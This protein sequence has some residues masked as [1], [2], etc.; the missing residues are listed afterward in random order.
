VRRRH[1]DWSSTVQRLLAHVRNDGITWVPEPL[2]FDDSEREVLSYVEGDPG[3]PEGDA[4]WSEGL[5]AAVARRLREW[6]D[7]TATFVQTDEDAWFNPGRLPHEVIA[8]NTFADRSHIFTGDQLVGVIH[9]DHCY[10]ASRLWDI[11]YTAYFYCPLAPP[12]DNVDF[13][14]EISSPFDIATMQQRLEAFLS[15]YGAVE[16]TDGTTRTYRPDEVTTMLATRLHD[17]ADRA[18]MHVDPN[19]RAQVSTYRAHAFWVE[20]GALDAW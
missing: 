9:F 8:H 13:A 17:M 11:A 1:S 3:V 6:H 5:L 19:L 16:L 2:G 18:D 7:S 12:Q 14:G 10:P 15:A 20:S 4:R